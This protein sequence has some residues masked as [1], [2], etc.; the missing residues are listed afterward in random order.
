MNITPIFTKSKRTSNSLLR[1]IR[2]RSSLNRNYEKRTLELLKKSIEERSRTYSALS[3]RDKEGGGIF[4]SLFG[5]SLLLKRLRGRGR[6]GSGG[7]GFSGV[8]PRKPLLPRGG[9]GIGRNLG[10]LGKFGKFGRVGPLAILGTGLDFSGRLG[11][12]QNIAQATIGAGGGLAG[13]LVGGAKGAAIGT[14]FGGPLGTLIGGIIGSGVGAFAGGGIA[15]LLTGVNA[16][17]QRKSQIF[18]DKRRREKTLFSGAL[19]QFDDTLKTFEEDTAPTIIA[20]KKQVDEDDQT[21]K[22]PIIIP[23]RLSTPNKPDNVK[24]LDSV[25]VKPKDQFF[26]R[27]E[28]LV[29]FSAALI[30]LGYIIAAEPLEKPLPFLVPI[31]EKKRQIFSFVKKLFPKIKS[32]PTKVETP[33]VEVINDETLNKVL[34]SMVEGIKR[35]APISEEGLRKL[36]MTRLER[37]ELF[38][39]NFNIVRKFNLQRYKNFLDALQ[40]AENALSFEDFVKMSKRDLEQ[41]KGKVILERTTQDINKDLELVERFAKGESLGEILA[42]MGEGTSIKDIKNAV[43]AAR[44]AIAKGKNSEFL[45]KRQKETLEIIDQILED[46]VKTLD[47]RQKLKGPQIGTDSPLDEFNLDKMLR[48]NKLEFRNLLDALKLLREGTPLSSNLEP[49]FSSN[50]ASIINNQQPVSDIDMPVLG[51][52]SG[53]QLALAPKKI[54]TII[55]D[56]DNIAMTSNNLIVMNNP[57]TIRP[58][59]LGGSR[60]RT[61]VIK[62]ESFDAVAKYAQMTGLLTV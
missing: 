31:I 12:G 27:P 58:M 57:T 26:K 13:A 22:I 25:K 52:Q 53:D 10:R 56:S 35:G 45:T 30:T 4:G 44:D 1:D 29:P 38:T 55:N 5:G 59:S 39:R 34:D 46:R 36:S 43:R 41:F 50:I 7:M 19:D 21:V 60:Q 6:G 49:S 61:V 15:D 47:F 16:D 42:D 18:I 23:P 11:S 40:I 3:K 17:R 14:A 54:E 37:L 33:K 9:G 62:N 32:K 2:R 20:F 28:F 51:A 48:E 24:E 8:R